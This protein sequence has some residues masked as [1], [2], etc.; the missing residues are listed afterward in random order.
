MLNRVG[1]GLFILI[2]SATWSYV[3]GNIICSFGYIVYRHWPLVQ[4]YR[5]NHTT[6]RDNLRH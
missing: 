3:N 6:S 1:V 5:T 2:A 4:R